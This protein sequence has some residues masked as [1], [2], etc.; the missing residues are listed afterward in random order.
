[1]EFVLDN[2]YRMCIQH[3]SR[4]GFPAGMASSDIMSADVH[5][6]CL[7]GSPAE[8]KLISIHS[9]EMKKRKGGYI[10]YQEAKKLFR[11]SGQTMRTFVKRW[12]E[13]VKSSKLLTEADIN[14]DHYFLFADENIEMSPIIHAREIGGT[15]QQLHAY[16]SLAFSDIGEEKVID[17]E[18]GPF[19][20]STSVLNAMENSNS[21]RGN[22]TQR[23][24]AMVSC[25]IE[26][27]HGL[28]MSPDHN[29][30]LNPSFEHELGVNNHVKK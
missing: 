4:R 19:Y 14:S 2:L 29:V 13:H 16:V 10:E 27:F 15:F 7:M 9:N 12:T 5:G 30:S 6:T 21:F 25:L 28:L 22:M 26:V 1:M 3:A 20:W 11:R 23:K 18:N 17:T 24:I 8:A